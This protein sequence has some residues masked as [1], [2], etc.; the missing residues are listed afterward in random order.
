VPMYSQSSDSV[1]IFDA[2]HPVNT[3]NRAK[4]VKGV[5]VGREAAQTPLRFRDRVI[6]VFRS[7]DNL[8]YLRRLFHEQVPAGPLRGFVLDSLHDAVIEFSSDGEGRATDVLDSDPIAMRGD[9]RPAVGLWDEV[10]RLNRV[11]YEDR[12]AFLHEH[13]ALVEPHAPRDGPGEDDE[14]YHMRMFI[15][16]SLR[17]PG[18]E[19]FNSPGPLFALREDQSTWIPRPGAR[20]GPYQR[21]HTPYGKNPEGVSQPRKHG[22][23]NNGREGFQGRGVR[24]VGYFGGEEP[25]RLPP[26]P[27]QPHDYHDGVDVFMY[28]EDD[29]PWGRGDPNRTPEQAVAE[30]WGDDWTTSETMTGAPETMGKAYGSMYSWGNMWEENGGTR[31]QRYQTIPFWQQGGREGYELDI[32]ETL[33]TAGRELDAPVR[34]WP[35]DRVREPRGQEYRTYGPRSGHMV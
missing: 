7:P 3:T 26:P 31:Y 33:G 32:E 23:S 8:N 20:N 10:R 1:S 30:Y 2:Q 5:W 9:G 11:F 16:D 6:A 21:P 18:L 24:S 25:G 4:T 15:S 22:P 17:P 14:P 34:R 19:H 29:A 28:G 12:L 27:Q 35:M 13:A